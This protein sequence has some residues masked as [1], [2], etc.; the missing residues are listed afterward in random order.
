MRYDETGIEKH[1]P[2]SPER[3]AGT[4]KRRRNAAAVTEEQHKTIDFTENAW[5]SIYNVVDNDYFQDNEADYIFRELAKRVRIVSF[6]DYLKRYIYVQQGMTKP[7]HQ[8]EEEEFRQV[9][10]NAFSETG[11]PQSF[12]P[13]TAKLNALVKNWLKQISVGRNVVFLLGFAFSMSVFDVNNFLRKGIREQGINA[14]NPF[15]VICWYCYKNGYRYPKFQELWQR[16]LDADPDQVFKASLFDDRTV[17]VRNNLFSIQDEDSLFSM[18]SELKNHE[19]RIKFSV[20]AREHFDR[21]Y[22]ASRQLIADMYNSDAD[23]TRTFTPEEIG[24]GDMEHVIYAAVPIDRNGNLIPGKQSLLSEQFQGKRLSRG[25]I[26]AILAGNKE[27]TR[28][29]LITLNFFIFS[30]K[31]E[32]FSTVNRRYD[33]FLKSTN[34]ILEA[35]DLGQLYTPNPYEA[36]I[37]MC[38]LSEDPLVTYAD[39][40]ALSYEQQ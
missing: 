2:D 27:V 23:S 16:F 31:V 37:L 10:V 33:A 13:T 22:E 6:G 24:P 12:T 39:V 5:E 4:E 14:K 40:V 18:L 36:F 38:I 20:T 29:D 25:A 11:T 1:R 9:V 3:T 30:Q 28:F 26:G 35:C 8:V 15:E 32:E 17:N 21:L 19:N 7:F 34:A